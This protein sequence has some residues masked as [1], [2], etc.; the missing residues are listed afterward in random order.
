MLL[1]WM[2][3][4]VTAC[5]FSSTR[6]LVILHSS[7]FRAG[8]EHSTQCPGQVYFCSCRFMVFSMTLAWCRN[9]KISRAGAWARSVCP[10]LWVQRRVWVILICLG[11]C[12]SCTTHQI[13][14]GTEVWS[15]I[16]LVSYNL[17]SISCIHP[18]EL[19]INL[20]SSLIFFL[21]QQFFSF[22]AIL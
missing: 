10:V 21:I 6:C 13:N 22:T 12:P 9:W 5:L 19:I 14:Q 11:V 2:L 15:L 17:A 20:N 18:K 4:K 7:W 3:L 16:L 1:K 8:M